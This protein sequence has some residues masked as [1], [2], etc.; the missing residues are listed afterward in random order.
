VQ[1]IDDEDGDNGI[2]DDKELR[3]SSD[4]YEPKWYAGDMEIWLQ[5]GLLRSVYQRF[6]AEK[7]IFEE[8]RK[9]TGFSGHL[10]RY[11]LGCYVASKKADHPE[12]E[13]LERKLLSMS[14][15]SSIF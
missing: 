13:Q 4:R 5:Q 7:A 1:S 3:D 9:I 14:T 15:A 8:L 11:Q 12:L 6:E 10:S 2:E